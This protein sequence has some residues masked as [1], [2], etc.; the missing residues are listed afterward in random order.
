METID[1]LSPSEATSRCGLKPFLSVNRGDGVCLRL[2]RMRVSKFQ[3]G[4]PDSRLLKINHYI[5]NPLSIT[6][7]QCLSNHIII[8]DEGRAKHTLSFGIS[9]SNLRS[10]SRAYV[11]LKALEP[12]A[13]SLG[14]A[15][16][17]CLVIGL[18]AMKVHLHRRTPRQDK[19][20][21]VDGPASC[22]KFG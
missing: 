21:L 19:L 10:T 12:K 9:T 17:A 8:S 6:H 15:V 20:L 14:R 1:R 3:V 7:A 13:S 5:P 16:H 22:T 2:H 4:A 18:I 11:R